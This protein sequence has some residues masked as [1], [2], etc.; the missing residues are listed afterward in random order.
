[1]TAVVPT[2][3]A[4]MAGA[5]GGATYAERGPVTTLV[6]TLIVLAPISPAVVRSRRVMTGASRT[7]PTPTLESKPVVS[8]F[9]APAATPRSPPLTWLRSPTLTVRLASTAN[10]VT[11]GTGTV[12][13]SRRRAA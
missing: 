1:M 7:S 5:A 4:A 8:E 3:N 2:V 6:P 9:V 13:A 11:G 12:S 10:C